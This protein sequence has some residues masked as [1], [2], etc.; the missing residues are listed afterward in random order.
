MLDKL[1][2]GSAQLAREGSGPTDGLVKDNANTPRITISPPPCPKSL[3]LN[4]TFLNHFILLYA[5]D[6]HF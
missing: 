2:S 5:H 6:D 3:W 1:K 4:G